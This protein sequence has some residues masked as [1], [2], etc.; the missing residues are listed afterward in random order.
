[1]RHARLLAPALGSAVLLSGCPGLPGFSSTPTLNPTVLSVTQNNQ[2]IKTAA[3]TLTWGSVNN[4]ATYQVARSVA[5]ATA[6]SS[7]KV[8]ATVTTTSYSEPVAP[9]LT[10]T[11]TVNAYSPGGDTIVSSPATVVNVLDSTVQQPSGLAVDGHLG[12]PGTAVQPNSS[13]PTL[14]WANAS[15]ATA[16]YVT[17]NEVG[18]GN[19][20]GALTYAAL[21]Q[22]PTA[23]VGTLSLSN[24]TLAGFNQVAGSGLVK[25]KI[26]SFS[27]TAI[28]GNV[29]DLTKVT[30]IDTA[31]VDTPVAIANS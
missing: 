12:S 15:G 31:V 14:T 21:T 26:Y 24:V 27:V 18:A 16:Y 29:P 28:R 30:A 6:T 3:V 19:S 22:S 23:T 13:K 17:V 9:N 5:S 7:Q 2:G 25:G 11:Y 1:V 10:I 8:V 20:L 4:A